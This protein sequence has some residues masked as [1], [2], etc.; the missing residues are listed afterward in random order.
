MKKLAL[1]GAIASLLIGC[2]TPTTGII[3]RGEGINTVTHQANWD[4]T[5]TDT[6]KNNAILEASAYCQRTSKGVKVIHTKEIQGG[7]DRFPEAEIL[8]KCE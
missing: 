5:S 4:F 2:A 8:F 3:P 7:L 1:S 6:L